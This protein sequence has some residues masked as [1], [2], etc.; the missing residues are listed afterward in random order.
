MSATSVGVAPSGECLRNKRRCGSCGWQVKLCHPLAIGIG[1]ESSGGS[2]TF[3][4]GATGGHGF[5]LVA[6]SRNNYR[7]PTT[8]HTMQVFGSDAESQIS[9]KIHKTCM[10]KS[11]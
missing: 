1:G 3:S 11:L 4:W 2:G 6:F 7:F 10:L 8:N 9:R 5:G